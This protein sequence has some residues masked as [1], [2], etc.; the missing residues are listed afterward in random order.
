M[1]AVS[2]SK[3]CRRGG[4]QLKSKKTDLKPNMNET[5]SNGIGSPM[6]GD[7]GAD[8]RQSSHAPCSLPSTRRLSPS[9]R[10]LLGT[11]S[12]TWQIAGGHARHR[13]RHSARTRQKPRLLVLP[14]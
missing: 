5:E 2:R 7:I 9:M 13:G 11:A 1:H 12:E 8:G 4:G 14:E 6:L 10:S 3:R